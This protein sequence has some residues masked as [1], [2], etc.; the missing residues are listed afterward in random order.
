VKKYFTLTC[1]EPENDVDFLNSTSI[2]FD[3]GQPGDSGWCDGATGA[4]ILTT[5]DKIVFKAD[6]EDEAVLSLKFGERLVELQSE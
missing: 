3:I 1:V 2:V 4:R 6:K 5:F